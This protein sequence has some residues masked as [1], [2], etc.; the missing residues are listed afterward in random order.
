M[1]DGLSFLC[2]KIYND[3]YWLFFLIKLTTN[4][5]KPTGINKIS[6]AFNPKAPNTIAIPPH[7]V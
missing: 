7:L 5:I 3:D 6:N 4:A 1:N 2:F